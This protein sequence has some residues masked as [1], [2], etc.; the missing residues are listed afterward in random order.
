MTHP[1]LVVHRD[2]RDPQGKL[3]PDHLK[4]VLRVLGAGGFV[5]LPSDTAYSVAA[6]LHTPGTRDQINTMLQRKE[7]EPISLSFASVKVVQRWAARNAVADRLLECFTPGPITV[8]R[9]ARK[10]IPK[11]LTGKVM[12]AQNRTIGVRITGSIEE[13]Q[14]AGM[15][16]EYP[17]TT[18]PPRNIS[19]AAVTSFAEAFEIV[20]AGIERIG[21]PLWC[22]IEGDEIPHGQTSTV[23]EVL[24]EEGNYQ[25]RRAG[26]IQEKNIRD[27]IE[28]R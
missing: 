4:V 26:P 1:S 8:V 14:V 22:A 13:R 3:R 9:P 10:R 7:D 11:E 6:W 27:C 28:T 12:R 23:V 24:G 18:V 21:S 17:V 25:I 15:G 2:D 19:S 5:L 16:Q 20:R